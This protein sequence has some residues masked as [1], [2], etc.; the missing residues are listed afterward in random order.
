[1]HRVLGTIAAAMAL[2]VTAVTVGAGSASA[3]SPDDNALV[4]VYP[5]VLESSGHVN[6][7]PK[8]VSVVLINVD[9]GQS[10]NTLEDGYN[11]HYASVPNGVYRLR[12]YQDIGNGN[13]VRSATSWWPGVYSEAAAGQFRLDGRIHNCDGYT[14]SMSGCEI[15]YWE[16]QLQQNRMVT[17]AV[18][19]RAGAPLAGRKVTATRQQEPATKFFA[20]TEASG[21]YS[22][23]I[24]PGKYDVSTPNGNTTKTVYDV[25]VQQPSQSVDITV[26]D[27]PAA[28]RDVVAVAGSRKVSVVWTSPSDDGGSDITGYRATVSPGGQSCQAPKGVLGCSVEGLANNIPYTVTVTANNAVG[29]SS[30]SAPSAAVTPFDPAPEAPVAV[31]ASAGNKSAVV[32][33][34]PPR[35]GGDTVL[36]YR[37]VSNP[38]GFMCSTSGLSCE[39]KGLTNGVGYI[40]Q[41]IGTSTGGD[42]PTSAAS[43]PVTPA[44]VPTAPRNVQIDAGDR[45]LFVSW[46]TPDDDGGA[47]VSEYAATAWPGGRTCT[48]TSPD[49]DCAIG[50]LT[51]GVSYMVTVTATN[52]VGMSERSPGSAQ[53][54]PKSSLPSQKVS[55]TRVALRKVSARKGRTT[56][57][58]SAVGA[59]RVLLSW[60]RLGGGPK[61]V[62]VTAS[63]GKMTL[64]G[65]GSRY[66]VR[67]QGIAAAGKA[68]AVKVFRVR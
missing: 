11:N 53:A 24:P 51:N 28:P 33:W 58:W 50:G 57:K 27:P 59:Q 55:A 46:N 29:T 21:R 6:E 36:G 15:A 45:S 32:S 63:S 60:Q 38:G 47:T 3:N 40:F 43:N 56:V 68:T 65:S 48:T 54:T 17:G 5:T 19:N 23:L 39:V 16:V 1:M 37:V 42:S 7:K 49:R 67:V 13:S 61:Q 14:P 20:T 64:K 2:I 10:F 62:K 52:R 9:T 4:I 12:A 18:R 31:Q 26:L 22:L 30:A 8:Y 25:I 35:V 66:R 44:T 34:S 41:V